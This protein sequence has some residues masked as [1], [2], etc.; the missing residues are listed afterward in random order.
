MGA[1]R[2]VDMGKISVLR[3]LLLI[4][5]RMK[6]QKRIGRRRVSRRKIR[7]QFLANRRLYKRKE[8]RRY[9]V[10]GDPAHAFHLRSFV[11]EKQK[12]LV[13]LNWP[14]QVAAE[15]IPAK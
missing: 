7:L 5:P 12:Q 9:C 1:K 6:A 4:I 13:P 8:R 14:A 15:L 2:S 3:V 11:V 10:P